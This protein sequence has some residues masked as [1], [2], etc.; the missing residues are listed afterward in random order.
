MEK[1]EKTIGNV[2]DFKKSLIL[3][4]QNETEFD[5]E[6]MRRLRSGEITWLTVAELIDEIADAVYAEA[7]VCRR[8]ANG[9]R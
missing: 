2:T 8:N 1:A 7:Q 3:S 4:I 6:I 5:K 9:R